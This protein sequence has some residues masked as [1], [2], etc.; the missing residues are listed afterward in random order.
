MS[1]QAFFGFKVEPASFK[2]KYKLRIICVQLYYVS[3]RPLE[4]QDSWCLRKIKEVVE[5]VIRC[6]PLEKEEIILGL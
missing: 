5:G 6:P 4:R 1:F 2:N 3:I